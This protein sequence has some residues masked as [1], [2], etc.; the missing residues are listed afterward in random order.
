MHRDPRGLPECFQVINQASKQL[1]QIPFLLP[2][3]HAFLRTDTGLQGWVWVCISSSHF[4]GVQKEVPGGQLPS[5]PLSS[6]YTKSH[7]PMQAVHTWEL[8]VSTAQATPH[9]QP[10]AG[11]L[12][13]EGAHMTV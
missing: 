5:K 9:R 1:N 7:C 10:S 3:K 2:D 12:R 4:P 6:V 13:A 11:H 8:W